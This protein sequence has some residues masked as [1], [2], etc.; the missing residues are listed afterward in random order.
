MARVEDNGFGRRL[1]RLYEEAKKEDPK[2]NQQKFADKCGMSRSI[3]KSYLDSGHDPSGTNI[4]S[5]AQ[6]CNV[7][8]D[9]LLGLSKTRNRNIALERHSGIEFFT[10]EEIADIRDS[11]Q[12]SA[13]DENISRSF[14]ET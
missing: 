4:L 3:F 13:I 5:V 8:T 6:A 2:M 12:Q 14:D 1:K 7:S 9:W 10:E 11:F